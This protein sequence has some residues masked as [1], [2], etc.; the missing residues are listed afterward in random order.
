MSKITIISYLKKLIK[1]LLFPLAKLRYLAPR[2]LRFSG[3]YK[4]RKSAESAVPAN[5]TTGYDNDNVVML[6]Y[7]LMCEVAPWDYPVMFCLQK[8]LPESKTLIDGGGHLGTK[9]RAW[10]NHLP[11]NDSLQWTVLDVPAVVEVGKQK[12]DEEKLSNLHF[13]TDLHDTETPDI[14]LGSGLLQYLDISITSLFNQLPSR[15]KHVIFNKVAVW[16]KPDIYTLENFYSG[17]VPYRIRNMN[18][19]TSELI[20]LGYEIVD[21]WNIPSLTHSIPTHP[22]L[23]VF[24]NKGYFLKMK[25]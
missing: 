8:I 1:S 6:N 5:L 22:E 14:F 4:N 16:D 9:Y 20:M 18:E 17:L 23:G 12:A 15:P 2:R 21:E 10:Q 7:Q 19:L 13:I 11:L 3:A 25:E 24:E